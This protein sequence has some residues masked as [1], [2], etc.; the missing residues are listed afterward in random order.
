MSH[1]ATVGFFGAVDAVTGNNFYFSASGK[2]IMIDCGLY[3]G[4]DFADERNEGPFLMDPATIDILLVTHAHIDHIGR[5]PKFVKEG[6]KGRIISTVPTKQLA[7][8]MLYDT[9]RILAQQ[10][11]KLGTLPVYEEQDVDK[12]FRQ[13]HTEEYYEKVPLADHLHLEIKDAGHMLGSAMMFL[14]L[15]SETMVFTGDLG[16]SPTPLLRDTDSIEGAKYLLMEAVYGDRN[17]EDRETRK[18]RLAQA[19][20]DSIAQGGVLLMPAFSIERTQEF[21]YELNDLVEHHKL[22]NVKIFVDSPLAIKATAVY[23]ESSKYFGDM[24]RSVIKSGDD[25]FRFPNLFF[26]ESRDESMSIWDTPGPKVI[27]AGSGMLNGGRIMHHFRHYAGDPKTHIMLTGYQAAGTIGRRILEG[28]R[29]IEVDRQVVKVRAKVSVLNGYSGHKDLD[30]L[31]EF[32]EGGA[33]TLKKVF[34]AIG[35][36]KSTMFLAQRIRDYLGL[37]ATVPELGQTVELEFKD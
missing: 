30:H 7:E 23:R 27:M 16:N 24:A 26:T 18:E 5:I 25:V 12:V 33:S 34:V 2:K 3:Q 15:G 20:R 10:A 13:W 21:L 17:H 19:I 1:T 22:P 29:S 9:V 37:D 11:K 6:F 36:P 4:N 32:V 8:I 28:D 14:T 31:V 35:E